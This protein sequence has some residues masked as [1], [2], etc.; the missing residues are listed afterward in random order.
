MD[1]TQCLNICTK[2][3]KD[4]QDRQEA[5]RRCERAY[6]GE[7]EERKRRGT[8]RKL[9]GRSQMFPLYYEDE[10]AQRLR[11]VVNLLRP[12]AEAKRGLIGKTPDVRVPV[13]GI[14][15]STQMLADENEM[16]IRAMWGWSRI[17]RMYGDMGWFLPIHGDCVGYVDH[18]ITNNRPYQG[19]RS[20]RNFYATPADLSNIEIGECCFVNEFNGRHAAFMFDRPD[21]EDVTTVKVYEYWDKDYHCYIT[22]RDESRF[23]IKN[24][25]THGHVPIVMFPN[26][27]V[28]GSLFGDSDIE[29]GIE[30]VKEFNRRYSIETE[31]IIRTLFAPWIV[32][33]P[34]KVPKEISLDPYSIIPVGEGGDVR[35]A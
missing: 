13:Y 26:I 14:D 17:G 23:L 18:D 19:V 8:W 27:A 21:F 32:K 7:Y 12:M 30:L 22:N 15:A 35:P 25:N 16:R 29:A 4:G 11:I 1:A 28:P 10:K 2:L 20:S 5:L 24:E 9:F 34:L 3:E 33:N 6:A 31:A